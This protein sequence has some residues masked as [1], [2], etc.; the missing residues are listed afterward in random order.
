[1]VQKLMLNSTEILVHDQKIKVWN[2]LKLFHVAEY[3]K[4][5]SLLQ[6]QVCLFLSFSKV[7]LKSLYWPVFERWEATAEWDNFQTKE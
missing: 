4:R 3:S 2:P 6:S 5:S 1:M 7:C